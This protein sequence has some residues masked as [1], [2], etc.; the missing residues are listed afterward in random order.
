MGR[1][2]PSRT[3]PGRNAVGQ[4]RKIKPA[5]NCT[6][7]F[8][9]GSSWHWPD[10]ANGRFA[11]LWRDDNGP[12]I[13]GPAGV[14]SS[15]CRRPDAGLERLS[16]QPVMQVPARAR[17]VET[18]ETYAELRG[19]GT[20]GRSRARGARPGV[21]VGDPA[22]AAVEPA[23][24]PS[25]SEPRS[26]VCRNSPPSIRQSSLENV[27]DRE[28]PC[29]WW[30]FF[31]YGRAV[32]RRLKARSRRP[33]RAKAIFTHRELA[34]NFREEGAARLLCCRGGVVS[35]WYPGCRR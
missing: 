24:S 12:R 26:R 23:P 25:P 8:G 20:A 33:G 28:A 17:L 5:F 9:V 18:R 6:F 29:Y 19:R 14:G 22:K 35:L 1:V 2:M 21:E 27:I 7:R 30:S 34:S 10:R 16:R 32:A 15:T 4:G 11:A 3:R 13:S 31:G